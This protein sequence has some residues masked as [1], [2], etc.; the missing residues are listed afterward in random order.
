[1]GRL[2][3][4]FEKAF[5]GSGRGHHDREVNVSKFFSE[6]AHILTSF[7]GK[8]IAKA[9]KDDEVVETE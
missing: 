1:V 7:F 9:A 6:Q 3:D 4:G 5:E 8:D 2:C